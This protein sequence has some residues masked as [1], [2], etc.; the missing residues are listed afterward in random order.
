MQGN[1]GHGW[2]L[3]FLRLPLK[4][5]GRFWRRINPPGCTA[6]SLKGPQLLPQISVIYIYIYI[7][8]VTLRGGGGGRALCNGHG[9]SFLQEWA[10]DC[11]LIPARLLK[12]LQSVKLDGPAVPSNSFLRRVCV[13]GV[14]G[15]G[16]GGG[17]AH[18]GMLPSIC[19]TGYGAVWVSND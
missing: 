1:C 15:G 9:W 14:G 13:C 3:H 16:G 10:A 12:Q 6:S 5:C 17:A 19:G 4:C 7:E 2:T 8:K 18:F 11:R